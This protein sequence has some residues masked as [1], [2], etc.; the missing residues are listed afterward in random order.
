MY[1]FEQVYSRLKDED[2]YVEFVDLVEDLAARFD[3]RESYFS[4]DKSVAID[5]PNLTGHSCFS[6]NPNG[7][8]H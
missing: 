7:R 4:R 2:D 1:V 6:I 3:V 8:L 5:N